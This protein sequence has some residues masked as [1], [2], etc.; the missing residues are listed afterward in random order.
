MKRFVRLTL[1]SA[2]AAGL[3]ACGGGAKL[4]GGKE[5]AAQAAFQASQPVGRSGSSTQGLLDQALASGATTI[6]VTANCTHG[7]KASLSMDLTQGGSNSSTLNYDIKYDACN[8]DG[9]NTYTGT[10]KTTLT[11]DI[12]LDGSNASASLIFKMN[13]KL[14]IEGDI[15][16]YV[17]ATNLT[18]T[19]NATASSTH[20][21]S[22]TLT[23]NGA[24]K[25]STES[26]TY[27]NELL[28]VIAGELP[29]A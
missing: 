2:L 10:M 7:G 28:S 25:T 4:G 26:Y 9:K 12:T 1:L 13:G 11:M 6:T 15:S 5:G 23:L 19:M 22:V 17:E 16:D 21:G 20:S 18:L 8:E 27:S 14:N 3:A 24:I 29:K